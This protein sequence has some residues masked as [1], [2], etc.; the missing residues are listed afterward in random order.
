MAEF[1]LG[2]TMPPSKKDMSEGTVDV[3]GHK[4]TKDKEFVSK[5]A[6]RKL[7]SN[8]IR[9]PFCDKCALRIYNQ[10][11]EEG[12]VLIAKIGKGLQ[13][14]NQSEILERMKESLDFEQFGPQ[15]FTR[16]GERQQVEDVLLDGIMRK[17][18]VKYVNYRC[19]YGHGIAIQQKITG[20]EPIKSTGTN[21]P[22]GPGKR[23]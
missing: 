18:M 5:L 20:V 23:R 10:K 8:T 19:E 13:P 1:N 6:L 22:R 12:Q 4:H 3:S 16:V 11:K 7:K 9:E 2:A 21:E 17:V 15:Y 14:A